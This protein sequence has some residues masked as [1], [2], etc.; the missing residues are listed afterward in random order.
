MVQLKFFG[1]NRDYFKYDLITCIFKANF[2]NKY[3]F[4]PMLTCHRNDNEGK[5]TPKCDSNK[6]MKL[7]E[8]IKECNDKS[9]KNW[10][11]WLEPYVTCY[12]TVEPVNDTYFLH[13]SRAEYWDQFTRFL[14][15]GKTLIF[16]D[17]DIGLQTGTANYRRK[18]GSEK[19]ILDDELKTL[20]DWLNHES[21]LMIYQHLQRNSKMHLV[22]TQKKL[23]Q[24]KSACESE[25]ACAYR[26]NDLAFIFLTK[27]KRIFK[28]L[29]DVLDK[30]SQSN[31]NGI[32]EAKHSYHQ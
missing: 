15:T 3:V 31:S 4:V 13:G 24:A 7:Y 22:A 26:E 29:Q 27:S 21:V 2:L 14:I 30:Y 5:I 9:L 23:L 32:S 8:H 10:E 11:T 20:F 28:D 16:V 12:Q 17:P 19:Y 6:S 25:F 1:D 18:R